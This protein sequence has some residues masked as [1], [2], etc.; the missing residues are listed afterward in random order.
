[1]I[2]WRSFKVSMIEPR[3]VVSF[4]LKF[5]VRFECAHRGKSLWLSKSRAEKWIAN[6]TYFEKLR[7]QGGIIFL[8]EFIVRNESDA[9]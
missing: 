4:V 8:K 9:S 3:F 7:I 1:M 2:T 6:P 5:M